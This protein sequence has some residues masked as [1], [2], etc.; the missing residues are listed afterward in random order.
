MTWWTA[1]G[2]T[3]CVA[4]YQPIGAASLAA[5][6][7]NLANPGTYDL[8]V[9]GGAS[10]PAFDAATG[11]G[12]D[13]TN[14]WLATG[15][16]PAQPLTI[17]VR[18]RTTDLSTYRSWISATG[19]VGGWHF[20]HTIGGSV[21][22]ADLT[23]GSATAIGTSSGTYPSDGTSFVAGVTMD[24][25]DNWAFYKDGASNGSG[26]TGVPD[27]ASWPATIG[28]GVSGLHHY[29]TIAAVYISNTTVLDAATIAA[30]SAAMAA[31]PT[32]PA[33]GL[34]VIAHHY[35]AVFGGGR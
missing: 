2:A 29:G 1:G 25:S 7:V 19:G 21:G 6:Y 24:A 10:A 34:P 16:S 27:F 31:L 8:A 22:K 26:T 11:W 12:F 14:R 5:S 4:A 3:G 30:V 35:R 28:D 32:S 33:L 15:I 17:L 18:A 9:G 20:Y 13:G 23:R